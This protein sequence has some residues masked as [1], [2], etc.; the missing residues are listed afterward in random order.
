MRQVIGVLVILAGIAFGLYA[1][2]WWA[3]IGGIVDVVEAVKASPVDAAGVAFGI[4]K[5][6]F[7]GLIGWATFAFVAFI[8]FAI[9]DTRVRRRGF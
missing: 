8:G 1:G 9:A 4:A 2:L 3:F 5:V 6:F 7:A